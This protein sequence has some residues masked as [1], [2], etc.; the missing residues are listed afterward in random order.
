MDSFNTS[1]LR[2]L[3][4]DQE[5]PCITIFLS[6]HAAGHDG[7]QDALRLKNLVGQAERELTEQGLRAPDAKKLL[8]PVRQLPK[9]PG[10]W[11]KRSNGLAIFISQGVFDRFR[12][13]LELDETVIVNRRFQVKPL[14]PL[15]GSND[16]YFVLAFSQNR[17]RFFK[18][19]RFGLD[20]MT[21]DGMPKDMD[22]ALNLDGA[23][24][25]SQVHS[26]MRGDQG[27]QSAVFHGQGGSREAAKDDLAQ[28]FRM[29]DTALRDTLRGQRA[30]LF[31]AAV[32]YLLPIYREVSSYAHIAKKELPGNPD[33]SPEH[34]LHV[35]VWPLVESFA[36]D[37]R[38][39]AAA[40]YRKLAGTGKTSDDI[41]QIVPA[42][43]QGQVETLFVDRSDHQ[44]GVFEPDTGKLELRSPQQPG[45]DDL[46]DYAAVQTLLHRGGVYAVPSDQSPSP[47]AAAVFRY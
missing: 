24:R 5:G 23:D 3:T 21:I 14:L 10:F 43:H 12:I 26:A 38:E 39:A 17:V 46:L 33:H 2:K 31:L 29:I 9:E 36:E 27:K 13:P 1:E 32:Q 37:A 35:R 19:S 18:G 16:R 25:G 11:E 4:L 47:P 34:E 41:R 8:D 6:T 22:Q 20:E 28:Y 44:W 45:D 15:L 40:K 42:A 7:Q 30:P